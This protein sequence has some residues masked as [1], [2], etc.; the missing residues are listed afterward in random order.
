M[1]EER[2]YDRIHS[3]CCDVELQDAPDDYRL[4]TTNHDTRWFVCTECGAHW[5]RHRMKG[6]WRVDPYDY[7]NNPKVKA[8]LGL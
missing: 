8:A 6:T 7:D 2:T 1:A 4:K 3:K 5:G